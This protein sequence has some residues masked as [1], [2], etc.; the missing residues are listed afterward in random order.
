M[1]SLDAILNIECNEDATLEETLESWALLIKEGIVWSLQGSYGREAA[2]LIENGI[3][4][5]EGE[6]NW[7]AVE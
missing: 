7:D 2:S 3:I 5:R 1:T 4:S 6:I